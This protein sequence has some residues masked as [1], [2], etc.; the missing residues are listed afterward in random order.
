M[1]FLLAV[2]GD[3][4]SD[5]TAADERSGEA[6]AKLVSTAAGLLD[7]LDEPLEAVAVHAGIWYDRYPWEWM[8]LLRRKQPYA[9]LLVAQ[10]ESVY[11][12]FMMEAVCRLGESLD[13]R[14]LP[15][16]ASRSKVL[17]AFRRFAAGGEAWEN[18]SLLG[19]GGAPRPGGPGTVA[20]VW[21]AAAKDGATTAAV[22][23]ALALAARGRRSVGLVDANLRNPEI[24]AGFRMEPDGAAAFALRAKLQTRRLTPEEL[25]GACRLYKQ[26][27][28]LHVLPGSPRR[29]TAGDM[30]PEMMEHLIGVARSAFD[31]TI[32]DVSG[33]PDNAATIS[34]VREADERWLVV[35]NRYA[36]YRRAWG[37]W[38]A[39]FWSY[40]GLSPQEVSLIVN[41]I[42]QTERPERIADYLGM[43]LAAA[44]PN[45]PGG[46]G[47]R[48]SDEGV[49]LYGRP[50][51]AAFS[52]QIDRLAARLDP[53]ESALPGWV[54]PPARAGRPGWLDRLTTR[55]G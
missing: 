12:S 11:D 16:G 5:L 27:G 1:T 17:Q 29:D 38:F 23:T 28:S 4:D 32:I 36:S 39:C 45:M 41:R 3:R 44:L 6:D 46:L 55:F 35:Q 37:E 19:A 8:P 22:N 34:A 31:I 18:L 40:C 25:L 42:S 10:D 9:R 26:R 52:E 30:T 21:S 43:R 15:A 2:P 49:P 20:V 33:C 51:A 14:V 48:A 13:I 7:R 53:E 50:E 54:A 47:L 24:H